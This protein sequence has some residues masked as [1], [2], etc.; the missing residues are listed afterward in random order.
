LPK[1]YRPIAIIP[2]LCKLFSMILLKRVGKLL[3]DAQDP[4]QAGFR[5]DYS[6]S[7]AVMFM[8]MVAEKADEWGEEVWSAS[9]DLEKAF[10]KVFFESVIASLTD[11]AVS[12][13]VVAYLMKL[14][15]Q[16]GAYVSIEGASSRLIQILRGVRQGDPM[17]PVLFNNVTRVIFRQLKEKWRRESRGTII[18]GDG[19]VKSTHCMFAD[20]T[21]L[22]ASSKLHLIAMILDVRNALAQHGLNLNL[23]KC[24]VQSTSDDT[25]QGYLEV[26][27]QHI[28]IVSAWEGFKVLGTQFTLLGRTSKELKCRISAA[29]AKFHTL[30]PILGKRDGNLHKR[31][32]LFDSCVGQSVLWC[33]ESW[34]LT[35]SEKRLLQSTQHN[36]LRRIAGPRRRPEEEWVEWVRRSTR[37]ALQQA[38][39]S[40]VRLWVDA[41][42]RSKWSWAGHVLRMSGER[43]ARRAVTWRDSQWQAFEVSEMPASL[44]IRRPFRTRWFRWEDELRRFAA[45]HHEIPWQQLAEDREG[46]LSC[47]DEFVKRTK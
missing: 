1:N 45:Q 28:P 20:D 13:D 19:S 46:W 17:S 43:L 47:C 38:R 29:W 44:R 32:R 4:E 10:D 21:T 37:A 5:P 39:K 23:E 24:L 2:V 30:W 26:G 12:T 42:L 41:H 8:R 16:Q 40:K 27:G 33:T 7:D 3:D 36:M 22:F 18:C 35:K 15:R 11:T 34:L 6:C 25:R 14:Y 31:L 9:L